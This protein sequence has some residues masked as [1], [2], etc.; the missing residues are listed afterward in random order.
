MKIIAQYLG[1]YEKDENASREICEQK[2]FYDTWVQKFFK[3]KTVIRLNELKN[4]LTIN[5]KPI[6]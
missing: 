5:Y 6:N 1:L 4:I 3:F 2:R